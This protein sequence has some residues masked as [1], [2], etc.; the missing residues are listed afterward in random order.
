MRVTSPTPRRALSLL[1]N[2]FMDLQRC[3][4]K[5]YTDNAHHVAVESRA[6]LAGTEITVQFPKHNELLL[7]H[8]SE[9]CN[10]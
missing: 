9:A 7:E 5:D 10:G 6:A 4:L 1:M 8:K 2:S 3:S